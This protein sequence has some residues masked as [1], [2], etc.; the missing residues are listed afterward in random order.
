MS[1]IIDLNSVTAQTNLNMPLVGLGT[2]LAEPGEVARSVE[3]A[4]DRGYKLIDCASIYGNEAEIGEALS[5]AFSTGKTKREDIWL[6]GKLWNDCHEAHRVR[7]ACE[8]T[9]A[10]LNVDYLDLYLIHFPVSFIH[11]VKEATLTSHMAQVALEETWSEMEK[12]KD[13]GLV[14]HIGVSNFS[15]DDIRRIQR[16]ARIQP[17]VNQFECHPRFSCKEL[18]AFCH[19]HDIAVTA[20]SSLGSPDNNMHSHEPLMQNSMVLDIAKQHEKSS[21]QVLL[22]WGLQCGMAVLPKS[23]KKERVGA[24]ADLF[25]LN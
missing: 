6:T 20:H 21:A 10:D 14:K 18:I 3:W 19:S 25:D 22:R 23:I 8:Q 1:K 24:N 9:L 13:A 16:C 12:L 15:I 17:E 4:I 2:W 11:G 5:K 7:E